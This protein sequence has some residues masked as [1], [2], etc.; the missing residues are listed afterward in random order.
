MYTLTL[1]DCTA[2]QCI[3]KIVSSLF[4]RKMKFPVTQG[5]LTCHAGTV[6]PEPLAVGGSYTR[7]MVSG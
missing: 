2:P 4:Y 3:P 6:W 7:V 5:P 1:R